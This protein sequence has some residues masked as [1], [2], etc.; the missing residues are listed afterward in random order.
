[1]DKIHFKIL[2][3]DEL[4]Y[5]R[6]K[7]KGFNRKPT[8]LF[9]RTD[10]KKLFENISAQFNIIFDK[11][12]F[13]ATPKEI[14]NAVDGKKNYFLSNNVVSDEL[15]KNL[16]A[17][18][19][20][21]K[22]IYVGPTKDAYFDLYPKRNVIREDIEK[23]NEVYYLL[24]DEK[25][26]R[27]F[28]RIITRLC[29]PYQYHYF[30]EPVAEMQYFSEKFSF[31]DDEIFLD[32]GVCD[33]QNILE[34][35]GKVGKNYKYIYGIEPDEENFKLSTKNLTGV[36][37]LQ[38]IKGALFSSN[39]E[40]LNFRSSKMTGRKGNARVQYDGDICVKSI[41]GDSLRYSPTF[42]KMDIEG[43]EKDALIG[44]KNTIQSNSPK[45]SVC[46]YHF[47]KDFWEVPL[48]IKKLNPE[49]KLLIRNH[50]KLFNLLESVCYAHV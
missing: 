31:C 4:K 47:Q 43:S 49:Y 12:I 37:N 39:N 6:D 42:I 38:L 50:E 22:Q 35:I 44:L 26:R 18:G 40:D 24:E 19:V 25:S 27:T 11:I 16:M 14:L 30:Y 34:F 1:M 33:G 13:D 32:A 5:Y 15:Y 3:T 48:L 45:L 17:T 28:L 36:S 7:T 23:I 2:L 10:E 29:L 9:C 46:I 21:E 41:S 8:I 20:S